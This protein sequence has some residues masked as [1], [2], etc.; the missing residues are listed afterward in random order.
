M[1]EVVVDA[2]AD[3]HAHLREGKAMRPLVEAAIVGGADVVLPMPNTVSGLRTPDD[4]LTYKLAAESCASNLLT[5]VPC[6]LL[7]EETT[8]DDVGAWAD[9]GI[10]DAKVYPRLR[11]TNS[12]YGVERYGKVLPIVQRCGKG[13]VGVRVHLHPEH[14]SPLFSNRDAEYAFLPIL[15]ML[16]EETEAVLVW[17]HGTDARCI[18]HWVDMAKSGRFYVTLTA[19]HLLSS[20]D[21]SLGD[22]AAACKP[23]LKL[24]SD[25]AALVELVSRNYPWV[26]AG[27]D[28]AFHALASKR[29]AGRPTCGAYTAPRLLALYAEALESLLLTGSGRATFNC[30]IS[31]NARVLLGLPAAL[32]V[33]TLAKEP[34]SIP[35]VEGVDQE[36]ALPFWG[37]R[38]I[39]W[40]MRQ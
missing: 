13:H 10:F 34:Q 3:V 33:V 1:F 30:F 38:T 32:R 24:E 39:S 26:M 17:E 7:T 36:V 29:K 37:G 2:I 18:S 8:E 25:R 12:A 20:E 35:W 4:V 40:S 19:H 16:L 6:A 15:R 22:A 11:T 9:A 31:R 23:P 28:S 27:S 21:D 5:V 14:P